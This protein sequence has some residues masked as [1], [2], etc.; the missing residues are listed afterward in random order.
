VDNISLPGTGETIKHAGTFA[1]SYDVTR[2]RTGPITRRDAVHISVDRLPYRVLAL[3]LLIEGCGW[4][5]IVAQA[6]TRHLYTSKEKSQAGNPEF[7]QSLD[8]SDE[9]FETGHGR[10]NDRDSNEP[11][12]PLVDVYSPEG[13]F[14]GSRRPMNGWLLNKP[15]TTYVTQ[16]PRKSMKGV[17][18][19]AKIDA[20]RAA[21]PQSPAPASD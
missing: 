10:M 17:K 5:E 7:L 15:R 13:R 11:N 9:A 21:Q 1:L 6:R 2:Q 12:W 8:L 19:Q 16:R 20:R 18:K 3:D 4:V 14:V